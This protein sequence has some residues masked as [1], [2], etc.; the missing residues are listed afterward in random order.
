MKKT[1]QILFVL[2]LIF[3]WCTTFAQDVQKGKE[4][5]NPYLS[6][7]STTESVFLNPDAE[8]TGTG[9][10]IYDDGTFENGYG[11]NVTVTEGRAV[12][13]FTPPS[14]P[15]NFNTVCFAFTQ[16]S[17]TT[18]NFDIVI[19]DD[20]GTAGAPGTIIT[21]VTGLTA[22]N[23]PAWPTL[24]WYDYA[25]SVPQ[26]T[27]GSWFIGIRWNN[28]PTYPGTFVGADETIANPH[29]PGWAWNNVDNTWIEYQTWYPNYR[30]LGIRTLGS[31]GP[32]IGPGPATNPN[33]A[34]GATGVSAPNVTLSWT[35]PGG[36]TS[37]SVYFGTDPGNLT[38]IYSGAPISSIG[39]TGLSYGTQYYWRVDETDGTG[40][41]T[42]PTWNFI[43]VCSAVTSFPYSE[44]FDGTAFPPTCWANTQ[45]N[46][47]GLWKRVTAGTYPTCA[48]HSGA[49]MSQYNSFNYSAGTSAVLVTPQITFPSAAYEVSF[50]M[51][52]DP[53]YATLADRVEVYY[54][55]SPNL[56]G[57]TLLGT[58]NRSMTLTPVVAVQGWY[59]YRFNMPGG[60]SGNAYI[61]FDG[62]SEYGNNMYVDDIVID[63]SCLVTAPSNPT[64]A[65]AATG[66]PIT[67]VNL[68]WT[69]GANT[70]NVEVWF[71][72]SGNLTKV[73]DGAVK[74]SHAL[75]TLNYSSPYQWYIVCKD[76]NCS[77]TGPAW[78]FTTTQDPSFIFYEPFNTI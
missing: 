66:V 19:Y 52:R 51:Y 27:S 14:Y 25:V 39:R 42:G 75:G 15:W 35:N 40:T 77:V 22:T 26:L 78:S 45:I 63:Q 54:N 5:I 70:T 58:I 33:P 38:Q 62:I 64:P 31:S 48:P 1:F 16:N 60:S 55:T 34:N 65:D 72:P 7:G 59:Q 9:Q 46:L 10:L 47:T 29:Q 11:W 18:L 53:G 21:A 4:I 20:D 37:N 3:A 74:T 69:N 6:L 73:Y 56:T 24:G 8:C 30:A 32:P 23:I 68:R 49:G 44:S 50:W 12:L 76:A 41:S 2:F 57:A 43:T 71:G 17:S 61:L 13:M 36:Q 67:G 28:V